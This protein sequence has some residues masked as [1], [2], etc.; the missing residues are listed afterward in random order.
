MANKKRNLLWWTRLTGED[1][2][3]MLRL[4]QHV[5]HVHHVYLVKEERD[6]GA[7][8]LHSSPSYINRLVRALDC[9]R[10]RMGP[11]CHSTARLGAAGFGVSRRE[12]LGRQAQSLSLFL[13]S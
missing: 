3:D 4:C 9:A 6:D 8:T 12:D 7:F 5:Q 13:G 1:M 10:T 11:N 2:L